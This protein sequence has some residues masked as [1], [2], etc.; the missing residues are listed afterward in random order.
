MCFRKQ[1]TQVCEHQFAEVV[2]I[3]KGQSEG[4]GREEDESSCPRKEDIWYVKLK[5]QRQD[6]NEQTEITWKMEIVLLR[7]LSQKKRLG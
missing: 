4:I 3:S 2:R 6:K 5:C 7:N 1:S